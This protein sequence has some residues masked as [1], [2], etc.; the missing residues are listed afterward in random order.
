ML[1]LI[2]ILLV[3]IANLPVDIRDIHRRKHVEAVRMWCGAN[4]TVCGGPK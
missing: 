4:E 1:T 2:Y 3:V